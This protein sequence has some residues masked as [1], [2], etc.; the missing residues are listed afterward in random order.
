MYVVYVHSCIFSLV[1]VVFKFILIH[2][3]AESQNKLPCFK[4]L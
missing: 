1:A 3:A 4:I 2:T